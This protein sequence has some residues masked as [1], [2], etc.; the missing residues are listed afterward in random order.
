MKFIS[1]CKKAKLIL[2]KDEATLKSIPI[3]YR[4]KG[5][6]FTDVAVDMVSEKVKNKTVANLT[7]FISIGVLEPWRGFDILIEAFSI[8]EKKNANLKLNI[9][10]DGYLKKNL[11]N[12]IIKK[13][14]TESITLCGQLSIDDYNKNM[15]MCDAVINPC[16]KEGA[17]TAAFDSIRYG[18]P[19]ICVETG[20][21]TKYFT[22]EYSYVIPR[23]SRQE[24][25]DRIADAMHKVSV[26][27][28]NYELASK[29]ESLHVKFS[30]KTKISNFQTSFENCFNTT[31]K[32]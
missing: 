19:L 20:G 4:H 15:A 7:T 23:T 18:K 17:V 9:I 24:V 12:L 10:G 21:F 6:I 14:L 29:L 26:A 30:W 13:G 25:I 32:N 2:C 8:A 31:T 28:N 22:D 27:E 5:I 1:R 3:E 11:N 16:L